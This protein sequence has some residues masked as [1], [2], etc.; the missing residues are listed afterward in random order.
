VLRRDGAQGLGG[1]VSNPS[2]AI[3][4]DRTELRANFQVAF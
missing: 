1:S 2:S 3:Q 4:N